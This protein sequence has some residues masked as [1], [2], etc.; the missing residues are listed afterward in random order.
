MENAAHAH[1][2]D[3][4]V[5]ALL[6]TTGQPELSYDSTPGASHFIRGIPGPLKLIAACK[7]RAGGRNGPVV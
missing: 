2:L 6:A 4:R 7:V 5:A 3:S 1:G